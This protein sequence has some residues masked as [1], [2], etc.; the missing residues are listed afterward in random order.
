MN[1][2]RAISPGLRLAG[3]FRSDATLGSARVVVAA[4]AGPIES[5]L[6]HRARRGGRV[7]ITIGEV[8][9]VEPAGRITNRKKLGVGGGIAL[10]HHAISAFAHDDAIAHDNGTVGLIAF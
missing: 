8:A 2:V 10:K 6:A 3:E 4:D 9:L 7:D 1:G 5:T